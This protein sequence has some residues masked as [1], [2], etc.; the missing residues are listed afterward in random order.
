[1]KREVRHFLR[2]PEREEEEEEKEMPPCIED[3]SEEQQV[4]VHGR[5]LVSSHRLPTL[6][7]KVEN[8]ERQ[9]R[10]KAVRVSSFRSRSFLKLVLH[11]LALNTK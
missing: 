11:T 5:F 4:S 9:Y 3:Y 2:L 8:E 7:E 1:M 10:L 6:N